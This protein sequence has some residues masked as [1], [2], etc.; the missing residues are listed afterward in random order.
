MDLKTVKRIGQKDKD[1]VYGYIK[2]I[3]SLFS[4]IKDNPYYIINQLVQDICLLYFHVFIDTKILT[5]DECTLFLNLLRDDN[6]PEFD[7]F[8]YKL[9]YRSSRDGLGKSECVTRVYDKKNILVM[10]ETKGNNVCGGYT[11]TG[12]KAATQN[13]NRWGY[14]YQ[15][16]I[17]SFIFSIRTSQG[18]KPCICNVKETDKALAHY[19][20]A[21]CIF[22]RGWTMN[23]WTDG[24]IYHNSPI[25]YEALPENDIQLLGDRSSDKIKEIEIYQL[26]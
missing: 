20:E 16:D 2:L 17:K 21:Y 26:V 11:S 8:E 22:G 9:L 4:D 5:E 15:K 12:W 14:G 25:S 7:N 10:V 3:Q 24:N 23:L 18:Y 6:K 19:K 13:E 1:I